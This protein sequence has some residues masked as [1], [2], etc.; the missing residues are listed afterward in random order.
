MFI[1]TNP[2]AIRR[3]SEDRGGA[4]NAHDAPAPRTAP[5]V[6]AYGEL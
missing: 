3:R 4:L 2:S 1:A 6:W 5:E